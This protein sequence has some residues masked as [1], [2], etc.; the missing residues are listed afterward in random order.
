M[1]G[2]GWCG[3]LWC[4]VVLWEVG[5]WGQIT[6]TALSDDCSVTTCLVWREMK[7]NLGT[8]AVRR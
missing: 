1:G 2:L 4:G 8:P 6:Q 7:S 5:G 3:V